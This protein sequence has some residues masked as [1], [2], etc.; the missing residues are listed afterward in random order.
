MWCHGTIVHKSVGGTPTEAGEKSEQQKAGPQQCGL[1]AL[2]LHQNCAM[3]LR[4]T[5]L[6]MKML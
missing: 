4:D 2:P 1:P 6:V 5:R 3:N